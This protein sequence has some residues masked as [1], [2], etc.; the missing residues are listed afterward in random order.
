LELCK[1]GDNIGICLQQVTQE[2]IAKQKAIE[3]MAKD[4]KDSAGINKSAYQNILAQERA[5]VTE[6]IMRLLMFTDGVCVSKS[7]SSDPNMIKLD[8]KS[9]LSLIIYRGI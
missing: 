2:E 8:S 5:K 4:K 6:D 9:K 1:F 3:K 7:E